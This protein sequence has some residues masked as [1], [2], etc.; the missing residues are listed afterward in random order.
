VAALVLHASMNLHAHDVPVMS[1]F[2]TAFLVV[3]GISLTAT[4]W[5]L[6]FAKNAGEQMRGR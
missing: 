5:N 1:D 4:F 3:T 6:R 2:S